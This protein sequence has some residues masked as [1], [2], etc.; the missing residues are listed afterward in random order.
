MSKNSELEEH[1]LS[2][3]GKKHKGNRALSFCLS[4]HK[5]AH[6]DPVLDYEQSE[7]GLWVRLKTSKKGRLR[8]P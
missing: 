5:F 6:L 2:V 8:W 4:T 1:V 7:R 3:Q